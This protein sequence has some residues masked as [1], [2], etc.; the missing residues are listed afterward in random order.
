MVEVNL[1]AVTTISSRP[2]PADD[3]ALEVVA[4]SV[5]PAH[6][7]EEATIKNAAQQTP[8]RVDTRNR[9]RCDSVYAAIDLAVVAS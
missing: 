4:A 5:A 9:G 8:A 6:W 3:S 2:E 7:N 1:S